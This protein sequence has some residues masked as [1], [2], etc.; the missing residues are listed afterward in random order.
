[1]TW[2]LKFTTDSSCRWLPVVKADRQAIFAVASKLSETD[3]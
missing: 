1:M 2:L 3:V